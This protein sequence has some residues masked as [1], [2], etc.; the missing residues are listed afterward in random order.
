MGWGRAAAGVQRRQGE[1]ADRLAD[2]DGGTDL[3]RIADE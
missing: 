3:M 2:P 1:P